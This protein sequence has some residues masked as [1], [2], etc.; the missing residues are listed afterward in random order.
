MFK[1]QN[2]PK[3]KNT[4][5]I[6]LAVLFVITSCSKDEGP[7]Y[8]LSED[9]EYYMNFAFDLMEQHSI[10]KK[11]IDWEAFRE[12]YLI[13]ADGTK[14]YQGTYS[15][16]NKAL[17][18]LD[19]HSFFMSPGS[20][21]GSQSKGDSEIDWPEAYIDQEIGFLKLP[22]FS[23]TSRQATKYATMLQD[24]IRSFDQ[25]NIKGWI[26][27]LR[28]NRGGN[29]YPMIAGVGPLFDT[30]ILGYFIMPEEYETSWGYKNG[31][32]TIY[33]SNVCTVTNYYILQ[34]STLKIA[35]LQSGS[36]ASSG[37]ATLIS[38]IGNEN[39]RTFG[40]ESAGYSTANASYE[41][42]DSARLVLTVSYMADRNKTIYG[43]KVKPEQDWSVDDAHVP[44]I[45]WILKEN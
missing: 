29:M 16:L 42:P 20:Y 21:T 38:F 35:V 24:S 32:S 19:K 9:A 18:E 4:F 33:S 1:I 36:T 40:K 37:E 13:M 14:T 44:A 25:K 10:R 23:G 26:V 6:L 5:F 17:K 34:N 30:D 11:E 22:A 3:M 15:V 31:S 7:G 45:N 41:M 8:E 43:E 12:K 28:E 27:D 2:F 39:T